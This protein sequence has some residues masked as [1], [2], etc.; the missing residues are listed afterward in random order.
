M[1][2]AIRHI[3]LDSNNPYVL[4]AFWEAVLGWPMHPENRPGDGEVLLQ[5]PGDLPNLLIIEVPEPRTA[6]SRMHFDIS[7][8]TTRDEELA[9]VLSLGATMVEDHRKPDGRGWVWCADPEGNAFCVEL[10]A[11][12]IEA[13]EAANPSAEDSA[14]GEE[15]GVG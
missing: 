5:S 15:V 2:S 11:A 6:K 14:A 3:T 8:R 7:P 9:R 10:S 13:W 12:E 4:G 1:T